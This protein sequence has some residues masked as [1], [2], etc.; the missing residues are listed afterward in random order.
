MD[1]H[2]VKQKILTLFVHITLISMCS[3]NTKNFLISNPVGFITNLISFLHMCTNL[4]YI[5]MNQLVDYY[6]S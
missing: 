3:E 2:L 1:S 4:V 5:G 6:K